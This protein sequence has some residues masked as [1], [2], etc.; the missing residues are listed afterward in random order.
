[1]A[2]GM[3]T[4]QV[5]NPDLVVTPACSAAGRHGARPDGSKGGDMKSKCD[6]CR[7][8][9]DDV[10]LAPM[11]IDATWAKLASPRRLLCADCCSSA[12]LGAA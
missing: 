4:I 5:R 9:F 1:M 2:A 10:P 7:R 8:S 11:L 6:G 12:R 3:G